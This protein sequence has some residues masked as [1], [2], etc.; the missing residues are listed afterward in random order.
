MPVAPVDADSVGAHE[1]YVER[2]DVNWN[3]IGVEK[4]CPSHLLAA[5]RAVTREPQVACGI[6]TDVILAPM[7]WAC[8][9]G[10]HQAGVKVSCDMEAV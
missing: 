6:M 7:V 4:R 5:L 9:P 3:A 1:S 10:S 2:P 8:A